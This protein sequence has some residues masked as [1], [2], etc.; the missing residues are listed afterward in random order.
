MNFPLRKNKV[1]VEASFDFICWN[2]EISATTKIQQKL[3]LTLFD[4]I[5]KNRNISHSIPSLRLMEL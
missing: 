4:R 3:R 5:N 2:F 1:D